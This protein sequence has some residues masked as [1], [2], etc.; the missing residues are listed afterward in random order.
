MNIEVEKNKSNIIRLGRVR[1]LVSW[2]RNVEVPCVRHEISHVQL[3][4]SFPYKNV[5]AGNCGDT[6]LPMLKRDVFIR[7]LTQEVLVSV[8]NVPRKPSVTPI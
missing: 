5:N 4:T 3:V 8:N 2:H 7:T 1:V 6:F